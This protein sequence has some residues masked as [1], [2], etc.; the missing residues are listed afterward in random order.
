VEQKRSAGV[1]NQQDGVVTI[2]DK[3]SGTSASIL[4]TVGFNCFSFTTTLNDRAFDLIWAEKGFGPQSELSLHGIPLLFPFAGRLEGTSFSYEGETYDVTRGI[5][6]GGNVIHGFVISRPWRVVA[7]SEDAVT[8]EFQASV[9]DPTLLA[10]WPA[11]FRIRVTYRVERHRLI[12]DVAVD[13]PD[14]KKLPFGFGTHPYFRMPFGIRRDYR[15]SVIS[16][17]ATQYWVHEGGLPTGEIREASYDQDF[18]SGQRFDEIF[19]D[20]VTTGLIAADDGLV[21][22]YVLDTES[23]LTLNQSFSTD[24]KNV[25]VWVPPHREAIAIEPWTTVPNAFALLDSVDDTGLRV[26]AP[27]ESW[28]TRITIELSE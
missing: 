5:A 1:T 24:F 26:L 9:D 12:C 17:R 21:H 4:T 25:V 22:S 11:D 10:Q 6:T 8:G 19:W 23:A 3:A 7:Q 13:N 15:D 27:G 14:D 2:S 18:E 20:G 16:F 28:A